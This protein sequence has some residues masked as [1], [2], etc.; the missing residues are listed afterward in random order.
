M[1]WYDP[2]Y[3]Y[4]RTVTVDNTGLATALSQFQVQISL[5]SGNFDFT[6]PLTDGS[7]LRVTDSD[8]MTLIPYWVQSYDHVAQTATIWVRVPSIAAS[9]THTIY[10]YYGNA[11]PATFTLPPT[12]KFTRPASSV[13]SGLA[14]NMVYDAATSKYYIVYQ[15]VSSGINL[16][17][18]TSPAGP[19]TD[20]GTILTVGSGGQWDAGIVYAPCLFLDSG[21]WYLYYSGAVST[22]TDDSIGY[23]TASSI[24][25]PYSKSVSNP[26]IPFSGVASTWNR[27]RSCEPY[28]YH[29]TILGQWVCLYMGD[30]TG[31]SNPV[32]TVGYAT[33]SSPGG[34]WTNYASN[35]VIPLTSNATDSAITADPWC[36]EIDGKAYIGY[37]G[38]HE[39]GSPTGQAKEHVAITSDF[40]TFG[41]LGVVYGIGA[42]NADFDN[43]NAFRGG[44]LLVSGVW[45]L[46][47]TAN[48]QAAPTSYNWAVAS[49]PAVSTAE[50][51]PPWCVLDFWDDFPGTSLDTDAWRQSTYQAGEGGSATVASSVLTLTAST[52]NTHHT[53][54]GTRDFGVGYVLESRA[55]HPTFSAGN[56]NIYN[57]HGLGYDGD[58]E[59]FRFHDNATTDWAIGTFDGTNYVNST[60]PVA[61]DTSYHTFKTAWK[62]AT[63]V[64]FSI[65]GGTPQTV[66]WAGSAGG[67]KPWMQAWP[68]T[69]GASTLAVDWVRVRKYAATDPSTSVGSQTTNAGAAIAATGSSTTSAT[70]A[71]TQ[72]LP[73]AGTAL[74][75]T[76][77]TATVAVH[78]AVAATETGTTSA[79]ATVTPVLPLA[80]TAVGTTSASATVTPALPIAATASSITSGTADVTMPGS[81]AIV[82]TGTGTT[83]AT[84]SVT[85]AL[86]ITAAAVSTTSGLADV[87]LPASN[88]IVATGVSTT[89]GSAG[90]TLRFAIAASAAGN[91][92]AT[93]LAQ[94]PLLIAGTS[95]GVTSGL[96]TIQMALVLAAAGV[97]TTSGT[98][99]IGGATVAPRRIFPAG[100]RTHTFIAGTRRSTFVA[101]QR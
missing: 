101:G 21:T 86:P 15:S 82:A 38:T 80:G 85:A 60:L 55:Q 84:A 53:L 28:V 25:G 36:V 73:L 76:S 75:T 90:V 31:T 74:G 45:Y 24:T 50:G 11:T 58:L 51:F 56:G 83:S 81:N 57:P 88:A 41:K 66:T 40:V 99:T 39:T 61:A 6:K 46:P 67:V 89:S 23:A 30:A 20:L 68:Q 94:Y 77:A 13:H 37:A 17:S 32:E 93:A 52:A 8:Q 72:N 48:T 70:A 1:A 2:G 63:T 34:P 54:V 5:T 47:Y 59:M 87:T 69:G 22:P 98:V 65:D 19:W 100:A 43:W 26:V 71:V 96:A 42:M 49:M 12:G 95:S 92:T 33:A 91:T 4:R 97:S 62:T 3:A 44:P 79:T 18:A 78:P 27:Y 16:S 9:S 14:E 35:P 7:D 10:L 64:D 29:S